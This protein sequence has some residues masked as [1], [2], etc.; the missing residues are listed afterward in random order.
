MTV[1][2]TAVRPGA[3]VGGVL[4]AGGGLAPRVDIARRAGRR[5]MVKEM[6]RNDSTP[7]FSSVSLTAVELSSEGL[8]GCG[9]PAVAGSRIFLVCPMP[10]AHPVTQLSQGRCRAI[11]CDRR[12]RVR[13]PR[14]RG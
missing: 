2:G 7:E 4:F 11:V 12:H 1:Y 5:P 6:M 8:G 10:L 14:H 3:Q 13:G 9:A